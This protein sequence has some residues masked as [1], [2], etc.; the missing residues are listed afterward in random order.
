MFNVV[1]LSLIGL[2]SALAAAQESVNSVPKEVV[3]TCQHFKDND[4]AAQRAVNEKVDAEC[5]AAF[6]SGRDACVQTLTVSQAE[7][8]S[9]QAQTDAA[10]GSNQAGRVDGLRNQLLQQKTQAQAERCTQA[11]DNVSTTCNASVERL[12]ARQKTAS[13][14]QQHALDAKIVATRNARV[15]GEKFF[16]EAATCGQGQARIYAAASAEDNLNAWRASAATPDPLAGMPD[17]SP[18]VAYAS[19]S[20]DDP[21]PTSWTSASNAPSVSTAPEVSVAGG[22][23]SPSGTANTSSSVQFAQNTAQ[24]TA[25]GTGS[26]I[27]ETVASTGGMSSWLKTG[28]KAITKVATPL[29]FVSSGIDNDGPGLVTNTATAGMGLAGAS[30]VATM[31]AGIGLGVFFYSTPAGTACEG[32]TDPVQARLKNC[33]YSSPAGQAALNSAAQTLGEP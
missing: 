11:R 3:A 14:G 4:T 10:P 26:R 24:T 15:A 1:V 22:S 17:T 13:I 29:G 19:A 21:M 12:L 20:G 7:M 25:T 33:P 27:A 5:K 2:V 28:A 9:L 18:R 23:E 32:V 31:S 6:T 30:S 8:S 16:D